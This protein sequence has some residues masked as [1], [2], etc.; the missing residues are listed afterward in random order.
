MFYI[1]I[2]SHS[3]PFV[4]SRK[5]A[6]FYIPTLVQMISVPAVNI[7]SLHEIAY[8]GGCYSGGCYSGG[9]YSG[10]CYSGGLTATVLGADA[11]GLKVDFTTASEGKFFY[12]S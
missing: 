11:T 8:S 6:C 12:F 5:K 2:L 1:F 4:H 7:L 10:G 3:A 9:C